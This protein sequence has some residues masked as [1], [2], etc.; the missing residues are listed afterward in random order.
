MLQAPYRGLALIISGNSY[1]Y[2]KKCGLCNTN[3]SAIQC[4]TFKC[5]DLAGRIHDGAVSWDG[6]ADRCIGVRHVNDHHLSL[7]ADLLPDTDEL[8]RLHGQGAEAYI[9]RIDP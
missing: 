7:L 9:G 6:P 4:L 3:T 1:T 5:N 2:L 8:I